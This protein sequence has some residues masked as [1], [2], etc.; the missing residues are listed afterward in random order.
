MFYSAW[1]C[2]PCDPWP[3]IFDHVSMNLKI[4]ERCFCQY[5]QLGESKHLKFASEF[6]QSGFSVENNIFSYCR[7]ILHL[8]QKNYSKSLKKKLRTSRKYF[9]PT[10]DP[11]NW[12]QLQLKLIAILKVI[13]F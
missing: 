12:I 10:R 5:R 4:N 11:V 3:Q 7:Q 1:R 13:F 6:F 8:A 9:F 2:I